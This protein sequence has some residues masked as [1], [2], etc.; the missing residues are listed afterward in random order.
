MSMPGVGPRTTIALLLAVG[1]GGTFATAGHLA[2]YAGLAP[3]TRQSGSS[4]RG[5]RAPQRGNRALKH[6][7]YLSAF[8]SLKHPPSRACYD[9]KRAEG[10]THVAALVCLARRRTDVLF[11]MIR[12]SAPTSRTPPGPSRR[13]RSRRRAGLGTA[14][15]RTPPRTT[16][17]HRG[18]GQ[19]ENQP[20]HAF[21]G[22][23]IYLSSPA[24]VTASPPGSPVRSATT[25]NSSAH[26]GPRAGA[27]PITS[28]HIG[29]TSDTGPTGDRPACRTWCCSAATTTT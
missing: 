29:I 1:D 5:E 14:H 10:K 11:A 22:G 7:L 19:P 15:G 4:L 27:T 12:A 13:L 18:H 8:A 17:S 23:E 9:R 26:G 24:W 3:V 25:S 2:A 6:L 20:G 16:G 21:P 28:H